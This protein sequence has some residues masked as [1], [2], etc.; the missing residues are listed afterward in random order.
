MKT[1]FITV[2]KSSSETFRNGNSSYDNKLIVIPN[3]IP[4]IKLSTIINTQRKDLGIPSEAFVLL[5]IGRLHRQK[6]QKFLLRLLTSLPDVYLII[7]G[8]GELHN[9]LK[10][11]AINLGVSNRVKFLG[12]VPHSQIIN[13]IQM[14]D[15]FTFPSFYEGLSIALLEVMQAGLPVITNDIPST[16]EIV[17]NAGFVIPL[18]IDK[19]STTISELHNNRDLR[20]KFSIE[21]KKAS[22]RYSI[23]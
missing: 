6:N 20:N 18:N 10:F 9:E 19:W 2:S 3:G 8:E 13:L 12:E 15:V 11:E 14:C 7:I 5:N 17:G 21:S 4:D 22:E 23:E 1:A 16:Q